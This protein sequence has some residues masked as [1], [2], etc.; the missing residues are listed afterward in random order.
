MTPGY[1]HRA[2]EKLFE[3]RD[4]RSLIMLADR[5]DWL[6]SFSWELV[7]TLAIEHAMGLMPSARAL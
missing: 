1:L 2:A 4:Y 6:S 3:V 7:V 5:R